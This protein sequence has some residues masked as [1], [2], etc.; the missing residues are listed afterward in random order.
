VVIRED[1]IA[2]SQASPAM[3]SYKVQAENNSLYNTLIT[4]G[5]YILGLTLKA[6]RAGRAR[7][8]GAANER[9][10]H[11]VCRDRS[12]RLLRGATRRRELVAD[13]RT[14]RRRRSCGKAF[15]K[16]ATANGLDGLKGHRSVGGMRASIWAT[17]SRK[18]VWTRSCTGASSNG[19]N[20]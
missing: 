14:F 8:R 1:L 3:L 7:R 11:A 16:Q 19:Q 4:F 2:R 15:D 18:T 6:D 13:E 5:V 20:G 12:H 9:K 10:A 17:L